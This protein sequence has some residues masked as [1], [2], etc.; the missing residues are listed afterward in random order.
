M[1]Y[2]PGDPRFAPPPGQYM[3]PP[4]VSQRAGSFSAPSAD[5]RY[6]HPDQFGYARPQDIPATERER[7]RERE[8]PKK[9]KRY[10]DDSYE[11]REKG[12][13]RDERDRDHDRSKNSRHEDDDR[14][15]RDRKDRE[16]KYHNDKYSS[17]PEEAPKKPSKLAVG[18]GAA[19]LGAGLLGV[20]SQAH[21]SSSNGGKPPASPLLE[22]YKGTYQSMSPMPHALVLSKHKDDSDLSD[23]DLDS[24][25]SDIDPR[26]ANAD[27]KRKI[28][29]LELEKQRHEKDHKH[30]DDPKKKRDER[31]RDRDV[32]EIAPRSSKEDDLHLHETKPRGRADS[33]VSTMV[34][35]PGGV[36]NKKRVTFYDAEDDAKKIAAALE[37]THRPANPKPLIHLLPP[38][39]DDDIMALRLSYK[40]SLPID[41]FCAQPQN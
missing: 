21:A 33:E 39:S 27:L 10:E 20:A 3:P 17:S 4:A 2:I 40:V 32:M 23:F 26:D 25:D 14:R 28:K 31:D 7:E 36:R 6:G 30:R 22:A 38:L 11:R 34:I 29:K 8:R 9:D 35:A 12:G 13:G 5:P 1:S 19:A 37:G 41:S 16:K 18:G 24:D 15:E